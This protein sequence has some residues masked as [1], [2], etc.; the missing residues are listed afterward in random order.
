[1]ENAS[2]MGRQFAVWIGLVPKQRS[3][4]GRSRLLGISKRGDRYLRTL[5][6]HTALA[7]RWAELVESRTRRSLWLLK[8]GERRHG[9]LVARRT[10]ANKNARIA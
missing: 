7:P 8:M 9:F 6:I 5:L 3:S 10:F 4:G 1:M 2:R